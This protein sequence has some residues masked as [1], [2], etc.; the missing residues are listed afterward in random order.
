MEQI[1]HVF[2]LPLARSSGDADRLPIERD[3]DCRLLRSLRLCP[4]V[5]SLRPV[6]PLDGDRRGAGGID[7]AVR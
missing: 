1:L 7:C 5:T 3:R 4:E 6:S 2:Y